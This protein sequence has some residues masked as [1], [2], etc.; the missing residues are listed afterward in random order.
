MGAALVELCLF[1]GPLDGL[2]VSVPPKEIPKLLQ[3]NLC[4][5]SGKPI[6]FA[7]YKFDPTLRR[8]SYEA[9][10]DR[11]QSIPIQVDVV[12]ESYLQVSGEQSY[13]VWTLTGGG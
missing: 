6:R 3:V 7:V 12:P 2:W 1:L 5:K 11:P 10:Y 9:S 4:G 13:K 8:F